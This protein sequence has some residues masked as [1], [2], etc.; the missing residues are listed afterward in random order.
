MK[1]LI[2]VALLA[3]GLSGF[4]Q[5]GPKKHGKEMSTEMRL[6]KMTKELSLNAEQQKQISVILDD[7][8]AIRKA[9]KENPES[10]EENKAKMKENMKKMKAVLTPEQAEK[11]K[12]N[13]QKH[14]GEGH[15]K[16]KP[17]MEE[18]SAE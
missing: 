15:G 16:E 3:I 12:A 4:A 10:K 5:E 1:K 14:H 11:M 9:I 17:K 6:K 18:K 7:Q 13:M 8:A 2:V